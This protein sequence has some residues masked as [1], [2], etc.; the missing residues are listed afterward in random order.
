MRNTV[1][2]ISVKNKEICLKVSFPKTVTHPSQF[3]RSF[4]FSKNFYEVFQRTPYF[5]LPFPFRVQR[6]NFHLNSY[7]C[8][9]ECVIFYFCLKAKE[10]NLKTRYSKHISLSSKTLANCF[11]IDNLNVKPGSE[12]LHELCKTFTYDVF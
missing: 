8:S 6:R 5:F 4:W 2:R 12:T 1:I 9:F 7:L 11:M 10:K 3:C